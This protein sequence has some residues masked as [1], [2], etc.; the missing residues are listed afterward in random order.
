MEGNVSAGTG[1]DDVASASMDEAA[2]WRGCTRHP[3]FNK[4]SSLPSVGVRLWAILVRVAVL[5]LNINF[6][7][8]P[9]RLH[10][11]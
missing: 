8:A 10:S 3:S 6:Y 2:H 4:F 1:D 9:G 5:E 11:Y 7:R